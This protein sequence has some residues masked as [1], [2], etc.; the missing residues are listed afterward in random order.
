MQDPHSDLE[1]RAQ[2]LEK[3]VGSKATSTAKLKATIESAE[4]YMQALQIADRPGDKK[5]LDRKF[6]DLVRQAEH[7]KSCQDAAQKRSSTVQPVSMRKL[8]TRENIIILDSSRLNGFVFKPWERT[9]LQDEFVPNEGHELF[10]DSRPLPLSTSQRESF[11]GW[12]RPR[13]ALEMIKIKNSGQLLPTQPTMSDPGKV[14]LV[15]DLTS[16]CSVVASLCAATSRVER[17]HPKVR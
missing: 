13:E 4:L 5:R 12:K 7:F 14:D 17:G 9:P 15:Q 16:D 10:I 8:T 11:G 1:S 3:S 6:N 2:R